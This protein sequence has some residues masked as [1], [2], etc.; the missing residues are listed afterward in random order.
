VGGE[1]AAYNFTSSIQGGGV[2]AF[3]TRERPW[4]LMGGPE[5]DDIVALINGVSPAM[6]TYNK[7]TA[8][9]DWCY[10]NIQAVGPQ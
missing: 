2:R 9:Q 1:Q 3:S 10:T 7:F 5:G 8:E 4:A 6:P